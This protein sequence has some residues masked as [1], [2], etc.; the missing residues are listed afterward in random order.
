MVEAYRQLA[1]GGAQV[2]VLMDNHHPGRAVYEC[3][4]EEQDLR[5]CTFPRQ[6]GSGGRG[7][8]AEAAVRSGVAVVDLAD[9]ICP[10]PSCPP[11]IGGVLLYRQ[12]SHLTRT[13]VDTLTPILEER[14]LTAAGL[15]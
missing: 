15:A 13:Y 10:T 8:Q 5:A 3:V 1:A 14:L 2:V 6:E 12:G 4:A 9:H 7:A 11:A